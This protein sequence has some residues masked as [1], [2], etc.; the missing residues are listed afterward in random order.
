MS[1][2]GRGTGTVPTSSPR[3]RRETT[4]QK[5]TVDNKS[6]KE[7]QSS[8]IDMPSKQPYLFSQNYYDTGS[9]S[10]EIIEESCSPQQI[11]LPIPTE[12]LNTKSAILNRSD[13][14]EEKATGISPDGRLVL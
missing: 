7:C 8:P 5:K 2:R 13:D 3:F 14:D 12:I 10:V 6:D 11:T 4:V 9:C 1:A